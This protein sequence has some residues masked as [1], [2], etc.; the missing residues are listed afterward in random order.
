LIH[1]TIRDASDLQQFENIT[2]DSTQSVMHMVSLGKA[3]NTLKR[4]FGHKDDENLPSSHDHVASNRPHA[5]ESTSDQSVQEF[6]EDL[7]ANSQDWLGRVRMI[8]FDSIREWV[9]PRWAKLQNRVEILAEKIIQEEMTSEDR[10]VKAGDA[11]F[12][13][14]FADAT[15]EESRIRCLAIVE[16]IH[17]KLFGIEDSYD[18]Q[19]R[20]AECHVV[21]KDDF[22][23]EWELAE[24]NNGNGPQESSLK[25]LRK[26][27]R[28]DPE[29]LDTGDITASAQAVIDSIITHGIESKNAAE[30][31]PLL[32]RLQ[33]LSRS[34]KVLEPALVASAKDEID[35]PRCGGHGTDLSADYHE[36][37]ERSVDAPLGTA[38]DDIADVISALETTSPGHSQAG[39][40]EALRKLQRARFE[41]ATLALEAD[42][43][44]LGGRRKSHESSQFAY[45]PIYRSVS[46]GE[47]IHQGLYRVNYSGSEAGIVAEDD[48]GKTYHLRQAALERAILEHSIQY[49]LD[50]KASSGFALIV[51]VNVE[52]LRGPSTQRQFSTVLRSAQL[53]VKRRLLVEVIGYS[54][55]D[56]TIAIRRAID[57]LRL[58]S[59]AIF[60]TLSHKNVSD[61]ER[62]AIECKKLGAH[63]I[64]LHVSQ[65]GRYENMQ[66]IVTQLASA[67]SQHS[68]LTYID[69]IDSVPVLAKVIASGISYVCAPALRPALQAPDD[70]QR[71]TFDDLFSAI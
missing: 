15:P 48:D 10:Y 24:S 50:R 61:L 5:A 16:S 55:A 46:Q 42:N 31:T 2:R 3:R 64:G 71:A 59:Q 35:G 34:L 20:I 8:R 56:H 21:H 44:V 27:F 37:K 17:E 4:W 18:G 47:R 22:V 32:M 9:G 54:Q 25:A 66:S 13:V 19:Q 52:T 70:A 65:L 30:L 12:L 40:L 14:F 57:E 33:Y 53:R 45:I 38:W 68:I 43:V 6:M 29:V 39:P 58:H 49:L 69:G 41:R 11:E 36:E 28:H 23:L 51:P 62:N 26:A 7:R 60:I 67:G 1:I 63:A